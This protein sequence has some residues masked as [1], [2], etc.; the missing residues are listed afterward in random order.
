LFEERF[1]SIFRQALD[2]Y[3]AISNRAGMQIHSQTRLETYLQQVIAD[4]EEF[5]NIS[6]KG[7]QGASRREAMTS[8]ELEHLVDGMK[9]TFCI[10]NYL[11]GTYYLTPDEIL[12][13]S[14]R[15]I[16]QE[17]KNSR[18]KALPGLSDIQDGLFKLVLYSNIDSLQLNGQQV[19]FSTR[20]KL[21]GKGIR[22]RIVLPSSVEE[23]ERF[24]EMNSTVFSNKEQ[25]RVR[26][27]LTETQRNS[28]MEVEIKG[29]N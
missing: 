14:E 1:V 22:D 6:L 26:K 25:T 20:L 18:S 13:E 9:A 23:M 15:Y 28:N 24:I 17:S 5:K 4:F 10:E 21:T 16:I 3:Q 19:S 27:L 8:H 29:N 11:G 7:S 12:S 2:A